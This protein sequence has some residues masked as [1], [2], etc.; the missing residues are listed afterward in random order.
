MI[1][2][3]S[4]RRILLSLSSTFKSCSKAMCKQ[5]WV[6]VV[7]NSQSLLEGL[8]FLEEVV[9]H[10]WFSVPPLCYSQEC[11]LSTEFQ[12]FSGTFL[13]RA[14]MSSKRKRADSPAQLAER[15]EGQE[16]RSHGSMDDQS[17]SDPP[18]GHGAGGRTLSVHGLG[19]HA[20]QLHVGSAAMGWEVVRDLA[21]R[22]GRPAG[23]LLLMSGRSMLDL[24]RA[25]LQQVANDEVTYVARI[26]EVGRAASSFQKALAKKPLNK[27]DACAFDAL[28]T[29]TFGDGF[30]QSLENQLPST[31]QTLTFEAV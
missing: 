17:R 13:R 18:V 16:P 20:F 22:L 23:S 19:G 24:H 12:R 6:L 9:S 15:S 27:A 5:V 3:R 25:L 10:T 28:Q 11:S 2:S 29:L 7:R 30:D 1:S 14:A 26:F 4:V 8:G 21:A 31:L